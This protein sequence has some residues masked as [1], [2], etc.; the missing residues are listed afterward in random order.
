MMS[1]CQQVNDMVN[2]NKATNTNTAAN[3]NTAAN[4]NANSN[5]NGNITA[6][7]VILTPTHPTLIDFS[8]HQQFSSRKTGTRNAF[9]RKN[10]GDGQRSNNGL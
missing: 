5:A 4:A 7:T 6:Q 9:K 3:N 8:Q 1:G 10:A 2:G